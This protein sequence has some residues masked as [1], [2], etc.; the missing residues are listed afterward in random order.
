MSAREGGDGGQ[1]GEHDRDSEHH[2]QPVMERAGDQIREEFAAD[3]RRPIRRRQGLQHAARRQQVR[4]RVDPEHRGEQRGHRR[5][6]GDLVRRGIRDTL[7]LQAAGHRAGQARWR[8]T[9]IR[10]KNTPIDNAVPLF[11]NVARIPDTTPR[12][13]AAR[14]P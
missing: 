7:V 1:H 4:Q 5:Q 12:C 10:E 8:P 11:R 6:R 13:S 2:R 14:C 9:T 3:D